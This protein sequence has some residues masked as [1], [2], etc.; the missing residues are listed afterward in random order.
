MQK[1][2]KTKQ[3]QVEL[4]LQQAIKIARALRKQEQ[5]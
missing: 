2:K 3:Q 4:H 5:K 1:Q